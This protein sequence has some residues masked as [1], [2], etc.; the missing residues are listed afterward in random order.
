MPNFTDDDERNSSLNMSGRSSEPA[1]E[2]WYYNK[3][4]DLGKGFVRQITDAHRRR[5][6]DSYTAAAILVFF[7]VDSAIH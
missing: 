1:R 4:R 5:V 7:A 2:N 6:I 3:A